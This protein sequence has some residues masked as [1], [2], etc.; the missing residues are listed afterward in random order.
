MIL[1]MILILLVQRLY[2]FPSLG[3]IWSLLTKSGDSPLQVQSAQYKIQ[4][5][6]T[7]ARFSCITDILS[8]TATRTIQ[9]GSLNDTLSQLWRIKEFQELRNKT[10]DLEDGNLLYTFALFASYSYCEANQEKIGLTRFNRELN[11]FPLTGNFT[12]ISNDEA[13][14]NYYVA[15]SVTQ[16]SIVL[17]WE[18]SNSQKDFELVADSTLNGFND[19]SFQIFKD[20]DS[21]HQNCSS[22]SIDND[23]FFFRGFLSSISQIELDQVVSLLK[24]A[25]ETVPNYN[26]V[27]TGHSLGGAKAM[28][29]AYYLSKFYSKDLPV[30]AVYTYAQPIIGSIAFNNHLASCIGSEKIIR[31]ISENDAVPFVR[32]ADNVNHADH[33]R[34]VYG[35]NHSRTVWNVCT[36][37]NNSSCG[38]GIPCDERNVDYH[39]WFAGLRIDGKICKYYSGF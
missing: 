4:T 28:I 2:A 26:I 27:I 15:V 24:Q 12:V 23:L 31:V 3:D 36:G 19:S 1:F 22:S 21:S 8:K 9:T 6:D 16:E 5:N 20:N 30:F 25:K 32:I 17:S 13:L 38:S 14:K 11:G 34:V 10:T 35:Y 18:G 39:S 37:P 33:V 7:M 29:S